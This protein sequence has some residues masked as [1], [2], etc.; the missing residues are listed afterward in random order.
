MGMGD[1][2]FGFN[3]RER[4][5]QELVLTDEQK[6]FIIEYAKDGMSAFQIASVLFPEVNMNK[7]RS[8]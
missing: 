3:T 6:P 1:E 7:N 4:K 5:K 8:E 2:G